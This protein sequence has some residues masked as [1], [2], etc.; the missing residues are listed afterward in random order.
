MTGLPKV[1]HR[2]VSQIKEYDPERGGCP[3]R[4]KLHRIE[5]VWEKPAAWSAQG[6]AVHYAIEVFE[7]S[8][9]EMS[10]EDMLEAFAESYAEHIDELT[11]HTPNFKMWFRSGGYRRTVEEDIERRW[12]KGREQTKTYYE[13]ALA[14][15]EEVLFEIDGKPAV[16]V[17]FELV[18]GGVKVIGYIDQIVWDPAAKRW[19][20]RDVKT[21]KVPGE[22]FQL[23]PYAL[24]CRKELGLDVWFG[25]FWM[26]VSGKPTFPYDLGEW[27]EERL[28]AEFVRLEENIQ[29]GN[30]EP[31]P[32]VDGCRICPVNWNCEYKVA[33]SF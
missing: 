33:D 27:T 2:S 12:E 4:Y 15:P 9:R 5:R 17:P 21:G 26:A 19:K 11:E 25:D 7:K 6:S 22:D 1:E 13:Y 20:V 14:H 28:T 31:N 8:R 29:A 24:W 18:L 23:G 10:L 30:Y 32:T 16:E 3:H